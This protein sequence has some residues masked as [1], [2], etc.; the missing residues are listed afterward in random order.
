MIPARK[1]VA[2]RL[3]GRARDHSL[4]VGDAIQP[5]GTPTQAAAYLHDTVEDGI[6]SLDAVRAMFGDRVAEL[7]DAVTRRTGETYVAFI[8]RVA[9]DPDAVALKLADL[10]DNLRD[11]PADSTLRIRYLRAVARLEQ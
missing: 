9:L 4:R 10:R 11:L 1:F 3:V 7:V 2:M 6:L 8:E 5:T